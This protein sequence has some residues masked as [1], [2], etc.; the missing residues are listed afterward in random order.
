MA[1]APA[2]L[3]NPKPLSAAMGPRPRLRLGTFSM[4]RKLPMLP[5]PTLTRMGSPS[6]LRESRP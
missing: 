1:S 5:L 6:M 2:E 4:S 3:P